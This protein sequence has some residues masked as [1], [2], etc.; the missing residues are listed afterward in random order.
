MICHELGHF[1][2][3]FPFKLAVGPVPQ[4]AVTYS[5][6]FPASEGQAD[7]FATKDCLWRLWAG[8]PNNARYRALIP[9]RGIDLC[10][11]AW[12]RQCDRDMCYRSL[13]V[14]HKMAFFLANLPGTDTNTGTGD[15]LDID[16][17]STAAVATTFPADPEP[18]CRLDTMVAGALCA[19]RNDLAV[20]PGLLPSPVTGL[21]GDHSVASET[22]AK[23]YACYSGS[24]ARPACWFKPD[25]P[26]IVLYDCSSIPESGMCDGNDQVTCSP[27]N[28]IARFPCPNGCDMSEGF[29]DCI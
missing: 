20:I 23:P 11:S 14:A 4:T 16:H 5:G 25:M 6:T 27:R 28:G 8:H 24:G 12:S 26:D 2:G 13:A 17:P 18:Q 19:K 21:Y 10:N 22:A 29:P 1:F 15:Y 9:Q 3:G 7:Y